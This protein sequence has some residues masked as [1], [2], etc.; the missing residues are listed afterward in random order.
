MRVFVPFCFYTFLQ[1]L[2]VA[3]SLCEAYYQPDMLW[4]PARVLGVNEQ[5]E[6]EVEYVGY[7][8]TEKLPGCWL[9]VSGGGPR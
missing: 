1:K 7:G 6:Y 5:A 3:G 9:R 4:Y 2:R 8:N